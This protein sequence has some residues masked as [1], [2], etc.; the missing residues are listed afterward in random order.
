MRGG[1]RIHVP[2]AVGL[3]DSELIECTRAFRSAFNRYYRLR[4]D[5]A[6]AER[7]AHRQ[8][9]DRR[10]DDPFATDAVWPGGEPA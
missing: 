1:F 10:F 6:A 2:V 8:I 5:A 4:P 3:D 7:Y 9:G